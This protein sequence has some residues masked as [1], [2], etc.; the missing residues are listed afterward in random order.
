M[1]P[2]NENLAQ[3]LEREWREIY[4]AALFRG[5]TLETTKGRFAQMT[6]IEIAEFLVILSEF[7]RQYDSEGP[8]AVEEDL[9]KGELLMEEYGPKFDELNKRR[10]ELQSAEMLFDV[11]LADY[12]DFT[13]TQIDYNNLINLYKLYKAQK[14]AREMWSKTLWINLNPQALVDGIEN[15]IKDFRKFP[16]SV[17]TMPVGQVLDLKMKQ[18]KNVVPLMVALKNEAM[19]E[20]HWKQLMVKTEIEFDM[21]PERFTLENM[22]AMELHRYQDMAEEIIN[23]AIKELAIEK[24]VKDI[25]D[26]WNMMNFIVHKHSLGNEERGFVLGATEEIMQVLEDNSMNLQSMAGSQ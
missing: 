25:I 3:E 1:D 4:I 7:V 15:Y 24:G 16:K 26:T 6:L 12:S 23:N 9:D 14:E 21:S 2:Q 18:F 11:P 19:R 20:R 22:F 17:R 8:G 13:R 5:Q 10:V